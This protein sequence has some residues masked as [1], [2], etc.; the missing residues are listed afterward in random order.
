[1]KKNADLILGI[2]IILYVVT[3]NILS[4][5]RIAFSLPIAILGIIFT[6]YHFVKEKLK[7]FKNYVK[8]ISFFKIMMCVGII[9]FIGIEGFII[10]YPK[11][12]KE[13]SDY[14]LV[15]GAG[16]IDGTSPSL[17]LQDRLEAALKCINK[18]NNTGYIVVSGGK[19]ND[20]NISEAKAMS[21]YL[22]KKGIPEEKIIIEDKSKN[23]SQNFIYSKEK[24]ENHSGKSLDEINVK[25][26]TTDFHAFR[27][28]ILAKRNGYENFENYSS[29]TIWYLIPAMYTREAFALVKSVIFD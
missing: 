3:I 27:S 24:I 2:L 17:I 14:I 5:A 11:Y 29:E 18:Y 4:G 10:A 22:L 7:Q 25:I 21:N 23:T 26:V 13:N 20:E 19:G 1:L 16:L 15:L 9:C 8:L 6:I 28:S 12:K